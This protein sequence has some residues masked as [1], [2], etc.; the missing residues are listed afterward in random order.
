MKTKWSKLAHRVHQNILLHD[1]LAKNK[2]ILI[3]FSGGRDSVVLFNVLRE[4]SAFWKWKLLLGHIDHSLRID[5]DE[6][7]TEFCSNIARK[8]DIELLEQKIN[9]KKYASQNSISIEDAARKLRYEILDK[10]MNNNSIDFMVTGH[11]QSDQA[12]TIMYR[13]LTGSGFN[14]LSGIPN[15]RRK[16]IRPIL[17]ITRDEINNY[18]SENKLD[19]MEDSSNIDINFQRNRIRN[20]IIPSIKKN[21][22]EQIESNL[23]KSGTAIAS[24]KIAI[25]YFIEKE[26]DDLIN[27]KNGVYKFKI[28]DVK[29]LPSFAIDE[30]LKSIFKRSLNIKK[31]IPQKEILQ[32]KYFIFKSETGSIYKVENNYQFI[33]NRGNILI[34]KSVKDYNYELD[35]N[36][37]SIKINNIGTIIVNKVKKVKREED[38]NINCEYF[39]VDIVNNNL[40]IKNWKNGDRMVPFGMNESKKVSDILTNAKVDVHKRMKYPV[41]FAGNEIIWIP[42][43]KRAEK[44]RI[45]NFNDSAYEIVFKQGMK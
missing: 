41:I 37:K 20:K 27:N 34:S 35:I 8:Y 38:Y 6:K 42:G 43:V 10:W 39:N 5:E 14:G 22:Y 16:I 2:K 28:S 4:L 32:L 3:A 36:D 9:V 13:L 25:N 1:L 26:F 45:N 40:Y 18:I 7:E 12:E 23:A 24:A 17:D 31:H 44:F 33:V 21:G 29:K 15:K 11:H 30:L 19:F